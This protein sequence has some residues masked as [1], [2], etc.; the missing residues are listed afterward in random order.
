M[1]KKLKRRN[2]PV[3]GRR[4]FIRAATLAS[5]AALTPPLVSEAAPIAPSLAPKAAQPPKLVV[6][7]TISEVELAIRDLVI[8]NRILAHENVVDAYGHVSVRHPLN[9]ERYLLSW[10]RSPEQIEAGD[11]IEYTLDGEPVGDKRPPYLERFI[12]GAIYAARPDVHAVVHAHSEEVLPFSITSTKLLPVIHDGAFIGAEVPVWDIA[13]EFGHDTNL[14]VSNM[15]QGRDLARRLGGN[16]MALMRGH[17]FAA[18][19][20]SLFEVVRISV[21]APRNA[22]V[23]R[24]ALL[25]GGKIKPL[26]K[27]EIAARVDGPALKPN[28]PA[29][30]RAWEYWARRAGIGDLL[31]PRPTK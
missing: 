24:A 10:S 28:T 13:D 11:I 7:T 9:P 4:G 26:S 6:E 18:A 17:G 15:P 20:S 5:A 22:H 16:S 8:A 3:V 23:L 21:Y 30:L 31:P 25:M 19:A 27:G 12:H 29:A 2:S 14:L 1:S